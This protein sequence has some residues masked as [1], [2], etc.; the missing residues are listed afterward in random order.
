MKDRINKRLG[1]VESYVYDNEY[2]HPVKSAIGYGVLCIAAVA[3]NIMFEASMW[4]D[5]FKN[6]VR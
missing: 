1:L 4:K 5:E 2:D 3:D 6:L